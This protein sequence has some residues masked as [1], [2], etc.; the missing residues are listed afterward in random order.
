MIDWM[1]RNSDL[2]LIISVLLMFSS[3][4]G[5]FDAVANSI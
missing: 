5:A 4:V 2:L 1:W 3:F